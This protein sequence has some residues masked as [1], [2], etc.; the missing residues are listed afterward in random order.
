[1]ENVVFP[2][3]LKY[4]HTYIF[5]LYDIFQFPILKVGQKFQFLIDVL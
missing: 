4:F 2:Y 5:R 3:M 1:M